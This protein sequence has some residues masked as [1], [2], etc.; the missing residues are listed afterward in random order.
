MYNIVDL[1]NRVKNIYNGKEKTILNNDNHINGN[2]KQNKYEKEN[3]E[4]F[5]EEKLKIMKIKIMEL[6][7]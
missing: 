3:R 7:Y 6:K 5:N 4:Y 2:I 1:S